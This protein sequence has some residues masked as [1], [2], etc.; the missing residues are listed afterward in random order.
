MGNLS[1]ESRGAGPP[2]RPWFG[3]VGGRLYTWY[4]S[5]TQLSDVALWSMTS[6]VFVGLLTLLLTVVLGATQHDP[7]FGFEVLVQ[8]ASPRGAHTPW[9]ALLVSLWGWLLA[10]AVV[11]AAAGVVVERRITRHRGTPVQSLGDQP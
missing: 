2:N 7:W 5:Y 10:P 9:L 1:S 4:R 8:L 6:G 3:R 11:G